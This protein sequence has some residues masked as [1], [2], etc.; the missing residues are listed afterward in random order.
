[1][2]VQVR[3]MLPEDGSAVWDM[4]LA[5]AHEQNAQQYLGGNF[6]DFMTEMTRPDQRNVILVAILNDKAVG[7]VS[8]CSLFSFYKTNPFFYMRTLYVLPESRRMNV[9]EALVKGVAQN[10]VQADVHGMQ[11][12]IFA[13]NNGAAAFYERMGL[14]LDDQELVYYWADR[15]ELEKLQA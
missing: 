5:L 13:H 9:G 3:S 11:W 12:D 6:N 1:M 10:A 4:F 7:F 8:Y 2:I 14:Q 15:E